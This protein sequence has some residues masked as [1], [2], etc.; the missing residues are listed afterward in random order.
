MTDTLIKFK[1]AKLAHEK[2]FN[3]D[4]EYYYPPV[5]EG[6][7]F[8]DL[9]FPSWQS[10]KPDDYYSAPT[11]SL[12]QR[13]LR[14]LPT[15]I[16]VTPKT[17]FVAWEVEISRPDEHTINIWKNQSGQLLRSYEEALE[18]GLK[19]ALKLIENG[20]TKD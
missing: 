14:E 13:W 3:I 12:L 6:Y 11:Q 16:I 4:T 15:S 18:E 19:E 2:G 20:K 7:A 17:D 9:D 1:T 10:T 5:E 8:K